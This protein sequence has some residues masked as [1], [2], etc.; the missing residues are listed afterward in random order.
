MLNFSFIQT[1]IDSIFNNSGLQSYLVYMLGCF[2]VL[3]CYKVATIAMPAIM[4]R[5]K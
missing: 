4:Q 5:W 1:F 3:A 2:G